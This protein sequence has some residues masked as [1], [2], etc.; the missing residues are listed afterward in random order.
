M[1]YR[2]DSLKL[3]V[4]DSKEVKVDSSLRAPF[5]EA[6]WILT[7]KYVLYE[8]QGKAM[9]PSDWSTEEKNSI[10]KI[11]LLVADDGRMYVDMRSVQGRTFERTQMPGEET[12]LFFQRLSRAMGFEPAMC[13]QHLKDLPLPQFF[14]KVHR[15]IAIHALGVTP[16]KTAKL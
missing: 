1:R 2:N 7:R 6:R 4:F 13:E 15:M 3:G 12:R 16:N 10:S 14:E 8:Q 5:K 9:H 11:K